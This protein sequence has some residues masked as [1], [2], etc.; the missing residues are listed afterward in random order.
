MRMASSAEQNL[1]AIFI[2]ASTVT[3]QRPFAL[4]LV[5]I[6]LIIASESSG[7]V[8]LEIL[9]A[10]SEIVSPSSSNEKNRFCS[11]LSLDKADCSDTLGSVRMFLRSWSK[12]RVIG[13]VPEAVS[14]G[15]MRWR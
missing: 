9:A 7:V 14:V 15:T 4:E 11:L 3:N 8:F 6:C 5:L 1:K 13:D 12:R 10:H 2:A